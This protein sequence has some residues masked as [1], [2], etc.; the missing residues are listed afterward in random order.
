MAFPRHFPSTLENGDDMYFANAAVKL[1]GS[2]L[3]A[4]GVLCSASSTAGTIV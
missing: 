1:V 4:A 2:A 3:L